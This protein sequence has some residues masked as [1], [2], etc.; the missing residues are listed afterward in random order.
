[1]NSGQPDPNGRPWS[2]RE[3]NNHI[4]LSRFISAADTL[5]R[6][7]ST[8]E[9]TTMLDMSKAGSCKERLDKPISLPGRLQA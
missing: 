7:I 2:G 8:S 3:I 6:A 1:M 9:G 5:E 4:R